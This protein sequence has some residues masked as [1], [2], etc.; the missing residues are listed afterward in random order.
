MIKASEL[1]VGNAVEVNLKSNDEA[2]SHT[3]IIESLND[4]GINLSSHAENVNADTVFS[5][6]VCQWLFEHISGIPLTPEILEKCGFNPF[7]HNFEKSIKISY[8][9]HDN[10]AYVGNSTSTSGTSVKNIKHLHQLQNLYFALT[11]EEL[12]VNL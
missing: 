10:F 3:V 7:L 11:G 8:S 6:I 1:R 2:I 12:Q 4:R 5:Q 9:L